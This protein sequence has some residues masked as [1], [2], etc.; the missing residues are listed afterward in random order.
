MKQKRASQK[1]PN[2]LNSST[3]TSPKGTVPKATTATTALQKAKPTT[4]V[5]NI[6]GKAPKAKTITTTS[7]K[8][9][10]SCKAHKITDSSLPAV[11]CY[12]G[13]Q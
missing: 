8:T 4:Q 10:S 13:R 5:K 1:T 9:C 7:I 12:N 6:S 11:R 3:V 2:M